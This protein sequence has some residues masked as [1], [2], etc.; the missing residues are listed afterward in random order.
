[1]RENKEDGCE[2]LRTY[3]SKE[4]VASPCKIW[5]A[6]RATSAAPLYFPP[7]DI[8]GHTYYDGGVISNNP[9][10]D[11]YEE[12]EAEGLENGVQAIVS[13]GTGKPLQ[14]NP[15]RSAYDTLSY[16]VKRM[17][18]TESDHLEFSKRPEAKDTYFRFNEEYEL[19]KINMADWK[20]VGRVEELALGYVSQPHIKTMIDQCAR[21][22]TKPQG[23]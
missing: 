12:A 9:I 4:G 13:I 23:N 3:D 2:R 20:Q 6:C 21:R 17:T 11:V 19:H 22:I 10:K 15:G 18:G 5:E 7:I 16:A 14:L 8:N 1:V